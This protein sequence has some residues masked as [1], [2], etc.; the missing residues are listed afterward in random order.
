M[1]KIM[2]KENRSD[3]F[4]WETHGVHVGTGTD[5]VK[6][7][8]DEI[9]EIIEEAIIR[10]YPSITFVI[11]TPRLTSY[12]YPAELKSNIKFIRGDTS[13]FSYSSRMNNIKK[14]YHIE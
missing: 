2:K 8:I 9:E 13:Y 11:H 3:L 10:K 12:R 7:G 5:P 4:I 1:K 14:K 6:H